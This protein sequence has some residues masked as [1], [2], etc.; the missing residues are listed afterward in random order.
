LVE[1]QN[2]PILDTGANMIN[3]LKTIT[4]AMAFAMPLSLLATGAMAEN[5]HR[6]DRL[7]KEV[8]H[9]LLMLP[10]YGVFDNLT[11]SVR[12][13]KV[14]IKGDVSRPTLKSDAENV[15]KRIEGVTQ[16]QN[17]INVL[18]LSGHDDNIRRA[19]YRAIYRDS[20]L[21]TRYGY[22]AQLPIHIIV[23]NGRVTLE[24]FVANQAD[25]N[26]V[27]IRANAVPG[28]FSVINNL[29]LDRT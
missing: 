5:T 21:A 16:V 17:S 22:R 29:Q 3:K 19:T 28:V 25:R 6:D 10:Y 14:V 13:G 8:R 26:L 24:G 23:K 2:Q 18:P 9:E 20:S 1:T 27:N 15:V 11:Y 7:V 4:R 12:D